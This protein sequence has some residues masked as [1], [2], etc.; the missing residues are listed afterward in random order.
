MKD[1]L[2]RAGIYPQTYPHEPLERLKAY[3]SLLKDWSAK[4]NL[5][6]AN[7]LPELWTR[8]FLDSAQLFPLLPENTKSLIDMGS[9]AGFPG[10]ILAILGVPQVHLIES[11]G[12]K[13]RFLE[14][15]AQTLDLPVKIHHA[16]IESLK[17]LKADVI[18]AR[19]LKPLPELLSLA[20]PLMK[21]NSQA[22]FLKGR[23]VPAELTEARKYWTFVCNEIP[24]R[25]DSSGHILKISDLR[26]TPRH[27][28]RKRRF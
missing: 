21:K 10:M 23:Q 12:K 6:S 7:S 22:L 24:S 15:V 18:T 25:S 11:I 17:G 14:V 1:F 8:H 19:A 13:A 9:G 28:S 5:V 2:A 4:I 26:A 16:R 27:D 3:E 20:H